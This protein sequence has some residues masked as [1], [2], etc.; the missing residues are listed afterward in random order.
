MA[1]RILFIIVIG[2]VLVL[3]ALVIITTL[4]VIRAGGFN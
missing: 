4:Q 1:R 2:A 3:L